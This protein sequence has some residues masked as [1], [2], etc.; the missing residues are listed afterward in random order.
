MVTPLIFKT[1][2]T[3]QNDIRAEGSA[4]SERH[5]SAYHRHLNTSVRTDHVLSNTKQGFLEVFAFCGGIGY[6]SVEDHYRSACKVE[7]FLITG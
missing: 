7:L 2:I 6:F 1:H 3:M 5:T 4:G